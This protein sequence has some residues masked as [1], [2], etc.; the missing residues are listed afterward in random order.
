MSM[1]RLSSV[2][3][4]VWPM[5]A[6]LAGVAA[7]APLWCSRFLPYQDAPQHLAAVT[8]L[9]GRS[10]AALTS[11]Q[12]FEVDFANA[13]YSGVYLAAMWL[14]RLVGPDAAIRILLSLVALL[15]PAAAWMLLGSFGRDRRVAVF[16][17]ALFQTA[18]LFIGV[19]HFVA[20]VPV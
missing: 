14:A 12:F 7:A 3:P 16:A 20:G 17:P 2:Q 10:A 9:A 6:L 19:Y 8:V 15:L 5:A 18:P 13:Q 11:R 1:R 4:F